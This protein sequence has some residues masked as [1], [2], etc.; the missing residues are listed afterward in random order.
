MAPRRATVPT[1][2][3]RP[4]FEAKQ[5]A[6][7]AA[8]EE[9]FV[10]DGYA[11]AG[12]DAIAARAGVSKRTVY[13]HFGDKQTLFQAVLSR[14]N[15]RV[16]ATVRT[17]VEEELVDGRDLR[18]ALFAFAQRVATTMF[19]SS[20]YA[21]FRRLSS[22]APAAPRLPEGQRDEPERILAD[23]LATFA[24]DGRLRIRDP[25]RAMQHFIALTMRLAL[26]TVNEAPSGMVDR[27]ELDALI[28]DGVDV[29]LR[30]YRA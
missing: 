18:D 20:D 19:P 21:T 24:A 6:I 29:F 13:D 3:R 4:Q 14:A 30:A 28:G 27:P 8:A 17:A 16:V 5:A 12:V 9:L 25:Y 11:L 22:Q 26:D 1:P 7:L 15:E 10:A 2:G 23:R